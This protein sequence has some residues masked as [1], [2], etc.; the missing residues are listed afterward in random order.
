MLPTILKIRVDIFQF[1]V[2]TEFFPPPQLRLQLHLLQ[3]TNRSKHVTWPADFKG[4][5]M[6]TPKTT[7]AVVSSTITMGNLSH[8]GR[9]IG[10]HQSLWKHF[11]KFLN[12]KPN[13]SNNFKFI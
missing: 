12:T 11:R 6:E 13:E 9:F 2:S 3:K 4:R 8:H 7:M 10:Y 5:D 1:Q